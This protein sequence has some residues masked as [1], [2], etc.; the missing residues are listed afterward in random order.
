MSEPSKKPLIILGIV[1][2]PPAA[3]GGLFLGAILFARWQSLKTPASI[4]LLP[5]YFAHTHQMQPAMYTAFA[6]SCALAVLITFI[7][8]LMM[9]I[10]AFMKPKRELHGSARFANRAEI[11]QA[12]LLDKP[13]TEKPAAKQ[14]KKPAAKPTKQAGY[15]ALLLGK[16][17]GQLL[18]W[19]DNGFVLVAARTRAGKGVS[20][21]V[22][23]CLNYR[24]SMVVYDPKFENFLLTAG[25]RAQSGQKVFLFNPGG[26]MP[27]ISKAAFEERDESGNIV[28][29]AGHVE[30]LA[31]QAQK[32]GDNICSHRWNP[33]TY[34]SRNPLFTYRDL[35]NMAAI[36]YP[37][38]GSGKNGNA[39]W[40]E[41]A[42]KL[43][44]GL[45]LYM[46]ETEA[47]RPGRDADYKQ[48][49]SLAYLY[50][51]ATQTHNHN[52]SPSSD[53]EQGDDEESDN[54]LQA[55]LKTELDR[56]AQSEAPLSDACHTLL[57]DFAN[58]NAKTNADI[59]AT[60]TQPLGIFLDPIVEA[61]TSADDFRLDD[62]RRQRMTIYLGIKPT[63]TG[64]FA[65]LTNLFFSQLIN[66]NVEQGLPEN[67][68]DPQTGKTTLP[69]QCLL[70]MDEFTALG[71]VPAIMDG[72]SYVAGYGLRLMVIVQSPAQ[73]EAVYGRENART[74]FTNFACRVLF[75]PRDQTEA[76]E[77]SEI[78]GNETVKSKSKSRSTGKSSSHGQS[79]S[80]Q[81][82]A[83]MYDTEIKQMPMDKCILDMAAVRPIYADKIRYYDDPLF[84]ARANIQPPDIPAVEPTLSK[85]RYVVPKKEKKAKQ[86]KQHQVQI[87]TA[88]NKQPFA[89]F[90]VDQLAL[91]V[92]ENIADFPN[93]DGNEKLG[94]FATG[95][96]NLW[97]LDDMPTCMS[98]LAS[99]MKKQSQSLEAMIDAIPA[100][101]TDD[102]DE[103]EAQDYSQ[104]EHW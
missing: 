14:G 13:K 88:K 57:A 33:F 38:D 10:T 29:D 68:I 11:F 6:I 18:R 48:R 9:L 100:S 15:P 31:R 83:L 28:S 78:L 32:L 44:V 36:M 81:K 51:L 65:R 40:I 24:D 52:A 50:R 58:G 53:A 42:R 63:E 82:R 87:E 16:Y 103:W 46:I 54:N 21:I 79:I 12:G 91:S 73:I 93:V 27:G 7:P 55:W 45:S 75:T 102:D 17:K 94:Q 2:T 101:S 25:F 69:H 104:D 92:C 85:V 74:F 84:K 8:A 62:I 98:V 77:Y 71:N 3:L 99:G 95:I 89:Q 30:Q 19:T 35:S 26:L 49:S 34:I 96:Q 86:L 5:R 1:L 41:S 76:K 22:P 64:T 61:V 70:L 37:L 43:F 59:S 20:V 97:R 23:N 39:F 56:R 80:D 4:G 47:E 72:V 66:V 90:L 67:N 60:F